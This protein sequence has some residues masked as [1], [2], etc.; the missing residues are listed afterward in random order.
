MRAI[1]AQVRSGSPGR[2]GIRTVLFRPPYSIDQEPD[3]EDQV[4]P[5]EL[6][7]DM[8]YITVGSKIDPN[9]CENLSGQAGNGPTGSGFDPCSNVDP[10]GVPGAVSE[11]VGA[12]AV[13]TLN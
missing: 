11:G 12:N 1:S 6:T 5:L 9:D 13:A 2:L 4:R 10:K 7:Q 3:T 8:G